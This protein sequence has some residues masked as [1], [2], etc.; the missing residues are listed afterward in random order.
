[1]ASARSLPT[2]RSSGLGA[3]ALTV[4][5]LLASCG[6]STPSGSAPS[7]GG[8]GFAERLAGAMSVKAIVAD[9]ATLQ[10]IT[11]QNGGN[12]ADG[13]PGYDAAASFVAQTLRDLGYQV[14]LDTLTVPL[15]TEV[16][17]GLLKIPGAPSFAV[18]RDFKAML[19]SGSG[20]VSARV[21]AVGFDRA[22]N[23]ATFTERP[24]G[25][26]CA[27]EDLP[28]NVK[29][30]ILLV[31]PGPCYRRAQVQNAQQAG[32]LAIVIAWPQWEPGF[33][34]RPT[35]LNPEGISIPAIGATRQ[36]GLALADA[37]ATGAS[38]HLR[39]Q[40]SMVDRPASSVIAETSGGDSSHV[41]MLGGHL[42][43]AL[44]S[45]GINDNGSGT[46][47]LLEIARRM[48]AM[49][50]PKLKV[51][52]A[53][54]AGEE[55]GFWGSRHYV[56]SL[57]EDQRRAIQAYLNFDMLGSPNGGRLV[58]ADSGAPSGSDRITRLFAE[59][60][61]N[62]KLTNETLDVGG[63]S[64]HFSF[65]QA[66]IPTGGLFAGANMT[67][68]GE[69]ATRFGGTSGALMDA[70]YHRACDRTDGVDVPLLEDLSQAAAYA[71]GAL[72]SGAVTLPR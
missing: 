16:G 31:Q 68:T 61:D 42:D 39:I 26:G 47:T 62:R 32:A 23:P 15:F 63:A 50:A 56:M 45:P 48:A 52:F 60:F 46:M 1:M 36:V 53:F 18:G 21:E 40:T 20:E 22:A 11:D 38:V 4:T 64:D 12:R 43:S 5:L 27:A 71:T 66:G 49:D 8:A 7:P 44:D 17:T 14:Q 19:F 13:S 25:K 30:A 72:A 54:W 9:L 69:K 10:T 2:A 51:R 70:C 59:Y 67:K 41:V 37:A 28:S 24:T 35:L 58:Y 29:G 3:V 57:N 33:V 65:A 55:L 34:L 6:A